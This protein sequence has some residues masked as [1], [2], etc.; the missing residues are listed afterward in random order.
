[1]KIIYAL[2]FITLLGSCKEEKKEIVSKKEIV[3]TKVEKGLKSKLIKKEKT[4]KKILKK[5]DIWVFGED[6]AKLSSLSKKKVRRWTRFIKTEKLIKEYY[7]TTKE[8]VI[9]NNEELKKSLTRLKKSISVRLLNKDAVKAR[10]FVMDCEVDRLFAIGNIKGTT[11]KQLKDQI[12]RVLYSRNSLINKIN[13]TFL[14]DSIDREVAREL[15][16]LERDRR[17]MRDMR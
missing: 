1:M 10:V 2:V 5:E 17:D 6:K 8:E 3:L 16:H 15:L 14:I 7:R 13:R 11:D 9:L 12:K 4:D